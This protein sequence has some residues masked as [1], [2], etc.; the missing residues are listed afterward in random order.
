MSALRRR[1]NVPEL[2]VRRRLHARGLRYRVTWPVPGQRR[3]T[4]DIAFTR[5]RVAVYIDGC[6]WH[7]CP[8]HGTMPRSNTAWWEAKLSANR[9][10]DASV[11]SQ[12]E[13]L[14]WTVMRF[15]EHE[16]PDAVAERI[17]A[18]VCAPAM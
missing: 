10:R 3:R 17:Y 9:A 18:V 6:F 4:I 11:T 12:L 1:D 8:L 13:E 2:A 7:G 15:W 16:S 5:A 14:G